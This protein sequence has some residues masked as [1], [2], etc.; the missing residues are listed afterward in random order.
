MM[1]EAARMVIDDLSKFDILAD[2]MKEQLIKGA[3]ATV[4]VEAAVARKEAIKNIKSLFITRN[5]FTTRQVQFIPMPEGNH[6][7]SKIQSTVGITETA[8]YMA[9]QEEGGE[10]KPSKGSTLAIATDEARGGSVA[11]PVMSQ[12]RVGK[13]GKRRRVHRSK[14][15]GNSHAKNKDLFIA[16]VAK[17]HDKKLFIAMG[18][19][20]NQRNL[21]I[22]TSFKKS[23]DNIRFK[24]KQ[25]YSFDRKKTKTKSQ[26]W[27]IPAC[28]NVE[29]DSQKI[30]N[31]QMK[32]LGM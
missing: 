6:A 18:G 22:I 23:G 29:K 31:G 3:I 17:A 20:G 12:M 4:N 9:R 7:L 32:K 19:R 25:I 27:L 5:T 30:F 21:H 13:I 10:H 16:R 2:D 24:S 28:E 11:S 15:T 26:P 8:S 14:K 1:S